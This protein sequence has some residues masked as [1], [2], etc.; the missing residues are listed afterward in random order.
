MNTW[1]KVLLHLERRVDANDFEEWFRST[2]LLYEDEHRLIVLVPN[3]EHVERIT[4][5]YAPLIRA[6]FEDLGKPTLELFCIFKSTLVVSVHAL[7]PVG[8]RDEK[9][10]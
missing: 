1:N 2:L 3:K 5:V 7:L 9:T 4:T 10:S 8:E 6:I